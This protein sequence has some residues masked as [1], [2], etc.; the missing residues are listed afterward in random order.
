MGCLPELAN[1]GKIR[2]FKKI[3]DKQWVIFIEE[4]NSKNIKSEIQG[5]IQEN[6]FYTYICVMR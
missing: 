1:S 6:N 3:S 2:P 5:L 4:N